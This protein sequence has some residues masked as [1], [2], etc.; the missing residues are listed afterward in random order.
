MYYFI[1]VGTCSPVVVPASTHLLLLLVA[2]ELQ[3]SPWVLLLVDL[4]LVEHRHP[5]GTS[6]DDA[7]TD[8]VYSG[9]RTFSLRSA[10][11]FYVY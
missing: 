8:H 5:G 2:D 3:V 9:L 1:A 4:G 7:H 6:S 11:K 10:D